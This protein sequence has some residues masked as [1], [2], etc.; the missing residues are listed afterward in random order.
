MKPNWTPI[1]IKPFTFHM[2]FDKVDSC[3]SSSPQ[4]STVLLNFSFELLFQF[5][6]SFKYFKLYHLTNVGIILSFLLFLY[7]I[8]IKCL[9]T[10]QQTQDI[11]SKSRVDHSCQLSFNQ[12][13]SELSST[14]HHPIRDHD[15]SFWLVS[16]STLG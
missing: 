5:W 6:F 14:Q 1:H 3:Q 16:W 13:L 15:E 11:Q 7:N 9:K 2:Y 8:R 12:H 10:T 4:N